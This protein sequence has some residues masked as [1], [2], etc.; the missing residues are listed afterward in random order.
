[1]CKECVLPFLNVAIEI[2]P[3]TLQATFIPDIP[4]GELP[5]VDFLEGPLP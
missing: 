2:N 3:C 5:A 4:F 1:M